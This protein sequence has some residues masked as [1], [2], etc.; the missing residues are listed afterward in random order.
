MVLKTVITPIQ[1]PIESLCGGE[2]TR[3]KLFTA[4]LFTHI[5][6]KVSKASAKHT[7][8][9]GGVCEQSKQKNREA[10]GIFGRK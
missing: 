8:M 5:K 1:F 10:V 9:E 7:E 3:L 6:D 2:S 4:S